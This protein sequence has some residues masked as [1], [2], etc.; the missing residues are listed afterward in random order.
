MADETGGFLISSSSASASSTK[1]SPLLWTDAAWSQLLGRSPAELA[2]FVREDIS[3]K[4]KSEYQKVVRYLE[5][6]L[7][8][9][10]VV[11]LVG[12]MEEVMGGRIGVLGVVA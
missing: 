2:E 11:L 7:E 8:W 9:M 3:A 5:Q 10:R 4:Q 6:R 1:H 12:W